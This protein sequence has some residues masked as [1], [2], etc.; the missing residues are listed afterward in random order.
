VVTQATIF[1]FNFMYKPILFRAA[2]GGSTTG[3]ELPAELW[4][5]D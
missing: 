5:E 3:N 4:A 1:F 2:I